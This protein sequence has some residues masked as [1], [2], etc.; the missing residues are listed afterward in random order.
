[1]VDYTPDYITSL[2]DNEIFCF[3]SNIEGRH[4]GG[5]AKLARE[6]FG[7]IYG[8]GVGAQGQSYAIPTMGGLLQTKMYLLDFHIYALLRPNLKFYL[9]KIGLGIAGYKI[10]D[11]APLCKDLP[12]NVIQPK[13]FKEFNDDKKP[14]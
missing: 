2:E 1:M 12:N 10:E 6:K 11:I 3:G 13:E 5:A 7:A 4:D 8:K 9:T 14:R